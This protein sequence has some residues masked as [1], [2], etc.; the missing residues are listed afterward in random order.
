MALRGGRSEMKR[1]LIATIVPTLAFQVIADEQSAWPELT[2]SEWAAMTPEAVSELLETHEVNAHNGN[3]WNV[4]MLAAAGNNNPEV[5]QALLDAGADVNA[6]LE[7][8]STA[9][10]FAAQFNENPEVTRAL[11]DAGA[12]VNTRDDYD[13]TAVTLAAQFNA[14]PAVTQALIAAGADVDA[15][16]DSGA[17]A[18]MFATQ[19]NANPEVVQTLLDAGADATLRNHGG[20]TAWDIIQDN[21]A[22]KGTD[23]YWELNNRRFE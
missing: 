19:H 15:R 16:D 8:G 4:L 14:N 7:S 17:T 18:L 3:G 9:L 21:E 11:L 1:V 10:T 5:I 23:V 22:L 13:S 2:E 12:D 20:T 6:R